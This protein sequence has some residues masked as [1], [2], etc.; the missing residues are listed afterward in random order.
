MNGPN[1]PPQVPSRPNL[2]HQLLEAA[3]AQ[4]PDAVAVVDGGRSLS[5][6]ELEAWANRVAHLLVDRGATRGDRIALYL[7]KS[8]E[9]VVGVYAVMKAGCAYV[10][11]DPQ[12]PPARL[13]HVVR[14][15]GVRQVVTGR[16]RADS[17]PALFADT[18]DVELLV[19]LDDDPD[20]YPASMR[21]L[22]VVGSSE[23]A[24]HPVTPPVVAVVDLD[25]AYVLY[26]S[27]STGHPKGVMLS[28]LNA[29]SFVRWVVDEF[30]LSGVDRLSSH[31]PLH[32]DLSVLD[33]YAAAAAGATV[34]LV[35]P[36][37]SVFPSEV[38]R[39]MAEHRI[40]IWYSVP[41]VLS[42]L[43][44]KGGLGR[45][46]VPALRLV[47][48]AG[49]VFPTGYLRMLMGQLP[50]VRFANLYGPTETNVC[51]WYD[52]PPLAG[53]DDRPIPIGRPI[54]NVDVIVVGADG[55]PAARGEVG[56]LHV[57]GTTVMQGY[58][59]D[60][61]RT[62]RA[63]VPVPAGSGLGG[64]MY[65]TGDLVEELPDGNLRFLGRRDSQVKC[66]GYRIELGDVESAIHAH[67]A[68]VECAVVAVPDPLVSNRLHATVVVQEGASREDLLAHCRERLPA[69]MVPDVLDFRAQL[70]RTST[71]KV[72][73]RAL[74]AV[75]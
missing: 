39:F 73:R 4:R 20:L 26:T 62:T 3:A 51:T 64:V 59:G 27:G 8:L 47:L 38:A 23:V 6:G 28:H 33:L 70:P 75:S 69:Y 49:E 7:D 37:T 24:R 52:V 13:A 18:P 11:L 71:G 40:T 48:F 66:R 9:A 22:D 17:W 55:R 30:R 56:E 61:E 29:L 15:A 36:H 5:Y 50:G 41:S 46:D 21:Q 74:A 68:V 67:P 63:L 42:M 57:R 34:V 53:D 2:V 54:A 19:C 14:D 60:R 72:D 16:A 44:L 12:A 1:R 45:A 43:A 35:P 10:P 32:F 58:W 25:L 31:A 65:R